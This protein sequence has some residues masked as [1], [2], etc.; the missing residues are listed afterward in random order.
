ML[1]VSGAAQLHAWSIKCQ[2]MQKQEDIEWN[3]TS[4]ATLDLPIYSAIKPYSTF[5][6]P[7]PWVK[8]FLGR[9][10]FH[11]PS[12][13]AFAFNSSMTGGYDFHLC[14]PS[15]NWA[16]KSVSAGTHSSSTNFSTRSSVFLALSLTADFYDPRISHRILKVYKG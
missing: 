13:L 14:S 16:W 9:K 4:D 2:T 12:F 5:E 10:R 11:S 3:R 8:W 1:P 15:P 7:A 6:N